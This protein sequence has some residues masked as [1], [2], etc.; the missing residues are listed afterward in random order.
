MATAMV[1]SLALHAVVI[2]LALRHPPRPGASDVPTAAISVNLVRTAVVRAAAAVEQRSSNTNLGDTHKP[3]P[4]PN[5]AIQSDAVRLKAEQEAARRAEEDAR[6]KAEAEARRKEQ[7]EADGRAAAVRDEA[8]QKSQEQAERE[9]EARRKTQAAQ[10]HEVETG[11]KSGRK[12]EPRKAVV[13]ADSASGRS[14]ASTR[15]SSQNA[16][17]SVSASFGK[18]RDYS[19]QVRAHV[20]QNRP[21]GLSGQTGTVV[22][23]FGLTESGGLAYARISNSSGNS[24][25]DRAVLSALHG[26]VPFPR[27][28]KGVPDGDR[29]F[30]MPF[31]FR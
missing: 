31:Y 25:L 6:L 8:R 18:T 9:A 16:G 27:A 5:P 22:A 30:T 3:P 12:A 23:A 10:E 26:A 20:S 21:T 15:R 29:R 1:S 11:R 4:T 7:A 2:G 19:A 17:A 14:A 28:P 24:V 13:K